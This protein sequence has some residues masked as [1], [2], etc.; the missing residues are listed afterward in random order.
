MV[1]TAT[2]EPERLQSIFRVLCYSQSRTRPDTGASILR[3][4]KSERIDDSRWALHN[5]HRDW[6]CTVIAIGAIIAEARDCSCQ[7]AC[8]C[9][10][11]VG[12]GCSCCDGCQ[13][14][15]SAIRTFDNIG[16]RC[17][18]LLMGE[19]SAPASFKTTD[20]QFILHQRW[21]RRDFGGL[22]LGSTGTQSGFGRR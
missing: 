2:E 19:R 15:R 21:I 11:C 13:S 1:H 20:R 3:I 10:C 4:I 14:I 12:R 5:G 8:G 17:S 6:K 16:R 18:I 9:S 22:Y 7:V